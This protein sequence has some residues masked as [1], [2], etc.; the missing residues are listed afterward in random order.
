VAEELVIYSFCNKVFLTS[1]LLCTHGH[2]L[3]KNRTNVK[4]LPN[5]SMGMD[6]IGV[7]TREKLFKCIICRKRFMLKGNLQRHQC[8]H[9]ND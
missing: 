7:S 5:N 4:F 1:S 9:I 6:N 8:I 2:I 3:V